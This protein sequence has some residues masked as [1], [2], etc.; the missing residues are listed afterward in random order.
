MHVLC[1]EVLSCTFTVCSMIG[2][3]MYELQY[4]IASVHTYVRI[5]IYCTYQISMY[6]CT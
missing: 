2:H 6:V 4:N 5:C 1:V 3:S